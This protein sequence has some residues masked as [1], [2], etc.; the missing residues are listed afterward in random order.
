MAIKNLYGLS[1]PEVRTLLM[2][3]MAGMMVARL[4]VP[5]EKNKVASLKIYTK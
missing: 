4:G 3:S 2:W 1:E 5:R